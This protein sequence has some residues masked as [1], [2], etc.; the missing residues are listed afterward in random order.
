MIRV[1]VNMKPVSRVLEAHGLG[2][3]GDVQ[4][5]VTSCIDRRITKYMPY[6][7]SALST[8]KKSIVSPTKIRI[9][10]PYATYQYY[11]KVMVGTQPKRVTDKDLRYDRSKHPLA[12]P[13]WDRR[14][15]AAEGELIAQEVQE[16][17]R[18][19]KQ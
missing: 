8:K 2:K 19:R 4:M 5:F 17:V 13:F 6:R 16:Y 15:M 11:G 1:K 18:R 10:G 9:D 14:L 7:A 3:S 12:G